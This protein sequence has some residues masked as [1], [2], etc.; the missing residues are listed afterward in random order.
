MDPNKDVIEAGDAVTL[1]ERT[2][3]CPGVFMPKGT[4]MMVKAAHTADSRNEDAILA[5]FPPF[6]IQIASTNVTLFRKSYFKPN[7]EN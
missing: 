3:I 5:D 7:K 4:L 2:M 6:E 1:T